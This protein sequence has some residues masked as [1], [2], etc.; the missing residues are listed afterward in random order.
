MI[1][2]QRT[3]LSQGGPWWEPN[4]YSED[5]LI[6]ISALQ[7]ALFCE[8][9]IALIHVEQVWQENLFTAEGRLLHERVDREHH[10]SRRNLHTEYA[11]AIRSLE[12]GLIGKA[13]GGLRQEDGDGKRTDYRREPGEPKEREQV[14]PPPEN[15]FAEV[16]RVTAVSP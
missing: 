8:R 16:V 4:L 2:R 15:G 1:C 14:D 10:E 12:H 3:E 13:P 11:M 7:H 5:E 9:Q 6:P